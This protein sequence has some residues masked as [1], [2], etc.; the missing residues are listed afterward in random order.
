MLHN[1][2]ISYVNYEIMLADVFSKA[3][4]N[5]MRQNATSE[6]LKRIDEMEEEKKRL[7]IRAGREKEFA[8]V[9]DSF[10][11]MKTRTPEN[12]GEE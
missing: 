5:L 8:R 4:E 12:R 6:S 3:G 9:I 11:K 10:V 1:L 7:E 2:V